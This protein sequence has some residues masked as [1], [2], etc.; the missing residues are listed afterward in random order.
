[1]P[2]KDKDVAREKSKE[3][4]RKHYSKN[5][6]SVNAK[7]LDYY[8]KNKEKIRARATDYY[9]NNKERVLVLAKQYRDSNAEKVKNWKL[10]DSFGITIDDYKSMYEKQNGLCAIC[11]TPETYFD[12]RIGKTRTLSVDHDHITGKVRG[13][14]C[15][16]CNLGIGQFKDNTDLM[17]NAIRYIK[18]S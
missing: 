7:N 2:Y 17:L 16:S 8:H 10:K 6:E 5:K 13:L 1:M 11:N 12:K 15:K 3:R 4:K 18:E 14:L 9:H